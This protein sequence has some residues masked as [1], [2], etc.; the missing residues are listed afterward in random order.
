MKAMQR[1]AH[2][3]RES[4][5]SYGEI[6]ERMSVTLEQAHAYCAAY[7]HDADVPPTK[8][9][10]ESMVRNLRK[11]DASSFDEI[12]S[13]MNMTP[14]EVYRICEDGEREEK[15]APERC[16]CC[17]NV[18][19]D[20]FG[21]RV[22]A[23]V[24]VCYACHE[25]LESG[26]IKMSKVD[27]GVVE[28]HRRKEQQIK[29]FKEERGVRSEPTIAPCHDDGTIG[30]ECLCDDPPRELH[31]P[32]NK[33]WCRDCGSWIRPEEFS[34]EVVAAR[35]AVQDHLQRIYVLRNQALRP[36]A[37]CRWSE[38]GGLFDV[39]RKEVDWLT[40]HVAETHERYGEPER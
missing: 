35:D 21:L 5:M 24:R 13:V 28:S 25:A 15:L 4:G 8:D 10:R 26:R 32:S 40:A 9:K 14:G 39:M 19:G 11:Y 22:R 20:G 27:A 37:R 38:L 33:Y 17:L 1:E 30:S 34:E 12:A 36:M 3:L 16:A 31:V 7:R 6:G 18:P 23:G 29:E 2:K